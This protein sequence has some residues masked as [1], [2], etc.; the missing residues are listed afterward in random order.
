[1]DPEKTPQELSTQELSNS[2]QT[3]VA[4][5]GQSTVIEPSKK[6]NTAGD[7]PEDPAAPASS[8]KAIPKKA[9]LPQK[10]WFK[11]LADRFNIYLLL[12]ILLVVVAGGGAVI[13]ILQ[14]RTANTPSTI[15]NQSLSDNAL[16]QLANTDATVG[17]SKQTLHVQ[18]NAIFAGQV[19]FRN[20]L[21]VAGA[22]KVGGTLSAPGLNAG[23][24][25][26][27]DQVQVNSL[28]VSGNSTLQ[29]GLTVQKN[30]SVAG[31]GSFGTL[32]AQQVSAGTLQLNGNLIVT[33]HITAGGPI[34]SKSDGNA[35]GSGGTSSLSGSDT[36][37][38]ITINTGS[39]PAAGC[40][41]TINFAQKFSGTPRVLLT[42]VSAAAAGLPYYV[43]RTSGS[44]SVCTAAPAAAGQTIS[45]DYATFE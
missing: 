1:M 32:T 40:F 22:V 29:G 21:D 11:R 8:A 20:N 35:L 43:S 28:A 26:T 36:A 23:G 33:R 6:A 30:L 27:L 37:G 44:F 15:G 45:F 7:D 14:S 17:T 42:P 9:A 38:N 12:F 10:N 19:L 5:E 13:A 41:V 39:A 3:P 34:P 16:Q 4:L 24:T 31:T 18:S 2:T 25:S